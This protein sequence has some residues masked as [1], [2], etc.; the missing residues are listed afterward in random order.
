MTIHETLPSEPDGSRASAILRLLRDLEASDRSA[1]SGSDRALAVLLT[2][3][4][5]ARDGHS[6]RIAR[7]GLQ[8]LYAARLADPDRPGAREMIGETYALLSV[9]N[10]T[11]KR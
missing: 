9:V 8:Q 2:D 4:V 6:L 3:A 5:L 1:P 10:W 7:D 11:L